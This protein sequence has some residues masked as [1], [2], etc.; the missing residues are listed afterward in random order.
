MV[1]YL[2]LKEK[3]M[4]DKVIL[5]CMKCGKKISKENAIQ[6]NGIQVGKNCC[7]KPL[8]FKNGI[9]KK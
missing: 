2:H 6:Q 3:T 8:S 1:V 9:I 4:A 7:W 5:F